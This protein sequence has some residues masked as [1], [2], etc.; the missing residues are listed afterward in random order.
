MKWE[1]IRARF[2]DCW[3]LLDVVEARSEGNMRIPEEL[4]VL[5][6]FPD[7]TTAMKHYQLEHRLKPQ[8]ELLVLHTS[9]ET[10]EIEERRWVGI[11]A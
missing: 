7:S 2:P 1:Q 5:A 8:R 10:I 9:R 4:N 3:V 11:R 6:E